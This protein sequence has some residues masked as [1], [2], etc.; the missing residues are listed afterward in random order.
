MVYMLSRCIVNEVMKLR[1]MDSYHSSNLIYIYIYIYIYTYMRAFSEGIWGM[2]SIFFSMSDLY[3]AYVQYEGEVCLLVCLLSD[4]L[5]KLPR[6]IY[7]K[8]DI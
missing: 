6:H 4:S 8:R 7:I 5:T 2:G 1:A 3:V